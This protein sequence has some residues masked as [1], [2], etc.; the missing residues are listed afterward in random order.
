MG[1]SLRGTG[2]RIRKQTWLRWSRIMGVAQKKAM[3]RAT[4]G[5]FTFVFAPSAVSNFYVIYI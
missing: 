5:S 3:K 4:K 1:F 2:S